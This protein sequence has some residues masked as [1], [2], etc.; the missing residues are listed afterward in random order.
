MTDSTIFDHDDGGDENSEGLID[1]YEFHEARTL[2]DVQAETQVE[3]LVNEAR[4]EIK[5]N[6]VA[7]TLERERAGNR[8]KQALKQLY[9]DDFDFDNP[10][11]S[12]DRYERTI[13]LRR[14]EEAAI[15]NGKFESEWFEERELHDL[16]NIEHAV[17]VVSIM[18]TYGELA[19]HNLARVTSSTIV[20]PEVREAAADALHEIRSDAQQ[21]S[22]DTLREALAAWL[23][24]GG[25]S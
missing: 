19:E 10:P 21:Q 18:K 11:D 16:P 15:Y 25:D 4:D 9:D 6:Q 12:L 13:A 20:E 8:A 23:H 5:A 2:Y 24:P 7:D 17:N 3:R 1:D 14:L 22:H